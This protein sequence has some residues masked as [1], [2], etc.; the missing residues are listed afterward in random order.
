MAFMGVLLFLALVLVLS[1][2]FLTVVLA[3][4]G[5][6]VAAIY[7]F[8]KR[9][10]YMPQVVLGVAF[11]T[12]ILMAFTAVTGSIPNEAWLLF[13]AN[14]LWTVAYDTEYAMVDRD[15]DLKIG[16]RSTA[17][18]FGDL[19]RVAIGTLQ[20][21]F[22]GIILLAARDLELSFWF[23]PGF[24]AA[25]GLLGY[26]QYLIRDRAKPGCFAAFLN[27]HWVGFALFMGLVMHYIIA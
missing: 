13:S 15:D 26:Q 27:N 18:L 14:L 20:V 2:N 16:I 8:M 23:A 24:L 11:S 9:Y 1:T 21:L 22:L 12:G 17:I 6:L 25:A 4:V 3:A 19:D 7:P 10:T 5:A